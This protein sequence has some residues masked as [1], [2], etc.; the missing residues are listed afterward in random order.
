M[1]QPRSQPKSQR[2]SQPM[3]G[4]GEFADLQPGIVDAV[5]A[6]SAAYTDDAHVDV[7]VR[8]RTELEQRGHVLDEASVERLTGLIRGGHVDDVI[9][10]RD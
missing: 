1:T 7:A 5:E 2:M 6:T 3:S 8:L 4:H 9:R 10:Q